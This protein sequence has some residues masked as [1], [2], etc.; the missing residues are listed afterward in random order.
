MLNPPLQFRNEPQYHGGFTLSKYFELKRKNNPK[1][2]TNSVILGKA[3][4][5]KSTVERQ[6]VLFIT[7]GS[8]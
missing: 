1:F 2:W 6:I 5:F 8:T 3:K 4:F 7:P